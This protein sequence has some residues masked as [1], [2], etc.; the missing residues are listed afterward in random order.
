VHLVGDLHAGAITDVR[1]Y[2]LRRDPS[3]LGTPALHVQVGDA[4]ECGTEAQDR[5]AR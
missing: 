5:L 3:S 4:T 1:M 2:A